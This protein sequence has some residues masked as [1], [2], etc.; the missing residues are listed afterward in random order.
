LRQ[1]EKLMGPEAFQ[2]GA[3]FANLLRRIS[4]LTTFHT[5]APLETDFAGLNR[6][7]WSVQ[8][9]AARLRWHEWTRYSSR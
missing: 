3:L 5:D 7:G 2:L 6:A 8:P 9:Q 4:L 1:A